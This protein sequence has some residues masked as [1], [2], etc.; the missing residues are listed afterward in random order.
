MDFSPA[1]NSVLDTVER[2]RKADCYPLFPVVTEAGPTRARV[3]TA[4]GGQW[5]V[6][7]FAS[8]DYLGLSGL[9]C[10]GRGAAAAVERFGT[11]AYGA[12]SVGGF[13]TLHESLEAVVADYFGRPAALLFPTGMQAN[14]GVLATLA[15]PRDT[16]LVDSLDHGS[17]VMGARLSGA[18]VLT[19]RH[20][21]PGH[22]AELLRGTGGPGRRIVVVD[23]LFSADGDL[24]ALREITE[25]T[26]EHGALV[27][28]D[29]AHSAGA[30]GERG[31]GAADHLGVLDRV[32]VITGT[33]SK[34]LVSTG[35]FVCAD[36]RLVDL[37]RH[38][39]GAY[40]MTLG[41]PPAAV[42]ATLAA[43]AVLR[44]EGDERRAR[45]ARTARSL[46]ER[47]TAAGVGIAA[48]TAH[49][50]T[51][52][53]GPVD[54]TA[55]IARRLIAHGLMVAPLFPPAVPIGGARL[56]LGVTAAHTPEDVD[57]AVRLIADALAEEPA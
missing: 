28:V 36:E 2:W 47:L 7:V 57:L 54:R 38:S 8:A 33:F 31:R 12:Q 40:L 39:A 43:F 18:R 48:S 30:L 53:I 42:G 46:R 55:R 25:L 13:T 3:R 51:V 24:A 15:G 4:D 50:V 52:P 22:L 5:P 14:I 23:G 11:G 10:V 35:G 19:F 26:T 56:R 17:I 44:E 41:P 45:L 34:A 20:N 32:D 37:L 16:V 29:E 1:L 6:T 9:P 21:D 27:V 49:V